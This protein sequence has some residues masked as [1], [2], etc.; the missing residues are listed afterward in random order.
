MAK[1]KQKERLTLAQSDSAD[2]AAPWI[3][4]VASGLAARYHV[5]VLPVRIAFGALSAAGGLGVLAYM[6]LWMTTPTEETAIKEAQLTEPTSAYRAPMRAVGE[7]RDQQVTAGRLLV[8]GSIF[9]GFAALVALGGLFAGISAAALMWSLVALAGLVLVWRQGPRVSGPSK[10]GAIAYVSLGTLLLVVGT[11]GVLYSMGYIS[12]LRS[13][14]LTSLVVVVVAGLAL[15]PLGM[16]IVNDLTASRSREARETERA[17]IAAHLHDSV[18]QTLTLIRSAAEDPARVRGLA[19]TQEREL[20]SWLYTGTVEPETSVAEALSNQAAVVGAKYGTA[21]EVVTVGDLEPGP[22]HLA[23]IAAAT[24]A[25]TNAVKHGAPPV[26][27]YQEARAGA[28]EIYVKD[29]GPGFDL[30]EV[31][32]DRHGYRNSI[33]GR[34]QRVGGTIN[35]RFLPPSSELGEG[36]GEARRYSGTEVAIRIPAGAQSP[37][38]QVA[39][40]RERV[41]VSPSVATAAYEA[42]KP[43]KEREQQ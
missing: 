39:A 4:G 18:L 33:V 43:V 29:A 28:L 36:E 7:R 22:A 8:V 38:I 17:D 16:R 3:G 37:P 35:V 12:D 31:P 30:D 26:T 25:M 19:L 40:Q 10:R 13:G 23:A 34:V 41:F 11:I 2:K 6:F 20:R 24:E 32:P 14:A 15:A 42:P 9:L 1:K 27:V 5:P 21:I